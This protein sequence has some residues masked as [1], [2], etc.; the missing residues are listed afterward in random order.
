MSN[1]M[2][3]ALDIMA[4][5]CLVFDVDWETEY[6]DDEVAIAMRQEELV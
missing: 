6:G 5:I 3:K 4:A 1:W 2:R